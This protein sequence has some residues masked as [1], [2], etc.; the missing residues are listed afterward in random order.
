MVT[1]CAGF[2]SPPHSASPG[3]QPIWNV[4]G[5]IQTYVSPSFGFTFFVPTAMVGGLP[6]TSF[7]FCRVDHQPNISA[8]TAKPEAASAIPRFEKLFG[9]GCECGKKGSMAGSST[10][11][12][13]EEHTSEL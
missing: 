5:G 11:P 2:S 4:S 9:A 7:G 3:E 13:S 6:G 1:S 12:R 10:A 8:I